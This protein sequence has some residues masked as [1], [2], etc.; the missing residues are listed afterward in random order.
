MPLNRP[1]PSASLSRPQAP[2][3]DTFAV[4]L[5][6]AA[7][8]T[9]EQCRADSTVLLDTM[10]LA[11]DTL[12]ESL[13]KS[14]S[15]LAGSFALA[16]EKAA[17]N[18]SETAERLQ[19]ELD[20]QRFW[21]LKKVQPQFDQQMKSWAPDK[22]PVLG[23]LEKMAESA[24]AAATALPDQQDPPETSLESAGQIL[25]GRL[26]RHLRD[27]S[28][29]GEPPESSPRSRACQALPS[30]EAL[31]RNPLVTEHVELAADLEAK[32]SDIW[33]SL[34]FHFQVA[35]E[36]LDLLRAEPAGDTPPDID[37]ILHDAEQLALGVLEAAADQLS[38]QAQ[39]LKDFWGGLC[40]RLQQHG[41]GFCQ[42]LCDALA[43]QRGDKP[44]PWLEIRKTIRQQGD[45][46][47]RRILGNQGGEGP[48]SLRS[49]SKTML[50]SLQGAIQTE[51]GQQE[52]LLRLT[53]LPSA[54]E[55]LKRT[56]TF[57]H[58]YRRMFTLG[59]LKNREFMVARDENLKTLDNLY[60]RWEDGKACCLAVIGPEG[61]GKTSLA[62]CFASE[63][64]ARSNLLR[65]E[66]KQRLRSEQEVVDLFRQ[67]FAIEAPTDSLDALVQQLLARPRGM[68]MVEGGHNLALR[69]VGGG[70]AAEVF[71]YL[72]LATR[73]HF[74]WL[75][76]FRKIPWTR[77][78]Y[79]FGISRFFTHQ[80]PTLLAD[81]Q[82]I[83]Q[84][85]ML[86]QRIS[87]YPLA[88]LGEPAAGGDNPAA[89]NEKNRQELFFRELFAASGGNLEAALYYWLLCLDYDPGQ[90]RFAACHLGK[91]E[92]SFLRSL[93]RDQLFALAE[94]LGHGGL[95]AG[96]H[97]EIFHCDLLHSRLR[98]DF[99]S[100]LGL[101]LAAANGGNQEP[102]AY[103]LNPVYYAPVTS[104]LESMHILY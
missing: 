71:F 39:P 99:L 98:L 61:S 104:T 87:G 65:F 26:N 100:S 40:D 67:W 2:A 91:I 31:Q 52:K 84:A 58:L 76:T 82:E 33:S 25:L 95:T 38:A 60:K 22:K 36:E 102:I 75:I 3:L 83:R 96:E 74:L 44:G 18:V 16:R 93:E 103:R 68:L 43:D 49:L 15:Q 79:Q 23:L 54:V 73:R 47:R 21:L 9:L 66:I 51:A 53:D 12:K 89:E 6:E 19:T 88:F 24:R 77:M 81:Q 45:E 1:E 8:K 10:T 20:A 94:V 32:T 7:A 72:V 50:G 63:Y 101:L 34:R 92:F 48:M 46:L 70:R 5:D 4:T 30:T 69:V 78:D 90:K 29:L 42:S 35:N 14:R 17:E 13:Q 64:G 62:N 11:V 56:E 28:G 86:R 57:P 80:I 97:S 41:T 55:I 37:A 27:L 85:L 59:P